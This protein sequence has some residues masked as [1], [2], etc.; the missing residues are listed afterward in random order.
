LPDV[1]KRARAK[2]DKILAEHEPEP[3]EEVVQ[4]ELRAILDAAEQEL[5]DSTA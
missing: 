3:L 1:R 5:G 4:A 2:L